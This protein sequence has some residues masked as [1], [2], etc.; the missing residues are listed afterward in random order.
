[1]VATKA[2]ITLDE[3]LTLSEGDRRLELVDGQVIDVPAPGPLHGRI[4]ARISRCLSEYLERGGGGEV[5]AGDVSFRL[6]LPADPNRVRAPDVSFVSAA[7][8]PA[9]SIPETFLSG[10]PDLAVE[11]L[12]PSDDPVDVQQKVRDFLETGAQLV[13]I[14]A[15]RAGT[16]NVFRPDGSA[17][18]LKDDDALDGEHVL[19]G[20]TILLPDIFS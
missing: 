20:L 18:F 17:R 6:G 5:F 1:M 19:P 9:G 3:F 10:A 14:V 13:W 11:V 4:V 16:V 7:R 12:S 8:L 15:P 2:R